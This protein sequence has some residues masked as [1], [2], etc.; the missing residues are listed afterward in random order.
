MG[1]FDVT[2]ELVAL[3]ENMDSDVNSNKL[4]I[5]KYYIYVDEHMF[6]DYGITN[7]LSDIDI[8]KEL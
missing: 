8:T 5:L 1:R 7:M 2:M 4:E 6:S 3:W